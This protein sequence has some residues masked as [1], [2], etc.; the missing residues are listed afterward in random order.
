MLVIVVSILISLRKRVTLSKFVISAVLLG[1]IIPTLLVIGG[2][3]KINNR[4]EFLQIIDTS[5]DKSVLT[6]DCKLN[7]SNSIIK[8]LKKV[9]PYIA[10]HTGPVNPIMLKIEN[11]SVTFILAIDQDRK[12]ELW[13][14]YKGR[15]IGRITSEKVYQD[16]Y[17]GNCK[18][19]LDK[20]NID[21]EKKKNGIIID[22]R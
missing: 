6:G 17:Y 2:I 4:K 7:D 16:I 10:H 1:S 13:I 5:S 15:E 14:Y 3:K 11:N 18:E 22:T 9:R 8:E 20:R 12:E 19:Q 21:E